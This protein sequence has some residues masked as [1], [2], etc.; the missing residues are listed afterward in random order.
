[1]PSYNKLVR[2]KIPEIIRANGETPMTHIATEEEY[3]VELGKKLLEERDEFLESL[4]AEEAGDILEVLHGLCAAN[5]IRM[6]D[7]ETARQEKFEKRGGFEEKI[8]LDG[9]K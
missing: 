4:S 9:V 5:G 3:I 6:E 1:M 8:I 7:V 2:D